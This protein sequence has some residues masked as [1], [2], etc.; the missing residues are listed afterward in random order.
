MPY[1]L[2]DTIDRTF[3]DEKPRYYVMRIGGGPPRKPYRNRYSAESDA[4]KLAGE[5]PGAE[6]AVLKV[7]AIY[8]GKTFVAGS[9]DVSEQEPGAMAAEQIVEA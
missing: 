9:S 3:G 5:N 7:K 1:A 6:F 2:P 8:R 4:I